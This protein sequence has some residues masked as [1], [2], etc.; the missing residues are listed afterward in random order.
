MSE[1]NL[2]KEDLAYE[3]LFDDFQES[4]NDYDTLRR[5]E[6][7]IDGFLS[8]IDL[9]NKSAIDVGCGLGFFSRRLKELGAIVT[10]CDISQKCV[11]HVQSQIECE[12]LQADVM[13]LGET[14]SGRTYDVVVSSECVEHT[15]DPVIAVSEICKGV[16]PGG[17]LAIST[18]NRVWQPVVRSAQKLKLRRFDGY[19][20]FLT[21][22]QLCS[23]ITGMGFRIHRRTGVH[24]FPFQFGMHSFSRWIDQHAQWS[25]GVMINM[26][27]LAQ[28]EGTR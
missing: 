9:R 28:R 17:W 16:R 10:A 4:L 5:V 26:C 12:G 25:A 3:S 19:E 27:V 20:N 6:V 13:R 15:P 7:L 18:P 24:L 22:K 23:T 21:W 1:R 14:L 11:R 2:K 8:E